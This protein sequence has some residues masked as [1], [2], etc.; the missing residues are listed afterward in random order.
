MNPVARRDVPPV[1][2]YGA[3]SPERPLSHHRHGTSLCEVLFALVLL[4]AT[5]GWAFAA[6]AAAERALGHTSAQ[7]SALHRAERVLADLDALPCDSSIVR[8]ASEA[9]WRIVA[10]RRRDGHV[11]ID[12][13]VLHTAR[14]DTIRTRHGGWCD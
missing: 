11:Y 4:T 7:R 9:R 2:N 6:V 8:T 1:D 3:S 5:A 13:V 14:G 12:D 10:A